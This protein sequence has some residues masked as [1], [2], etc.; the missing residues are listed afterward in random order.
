MKKED[1][2]LLFERLLQH[3]TEFYPKDQLLETIL[4]ILVSNELG[5]EDCEEGGKFEQDG[6]NNEPDSDIAIGF[7]MEDNDYLDKEKESP[8]VIKIKR[9]RQRKSRAKFYICH[10]CGKEIPHLVG[11]TGGVNKIRSAHL[12][13]AH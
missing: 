5:S 2:M 10:I 7:P 12:F 3:V 1:V 11:R 4:S 8:I 6:E 9:K 13:S